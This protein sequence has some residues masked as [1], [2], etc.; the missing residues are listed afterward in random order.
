MASI[1]KKEPIFYLERTWNNKMK[2]PEKQKFSGEA[3]K[4]AEVHV[5]S[6]SLGMEF[7]YEKTLP[8]FCQVGDELSWS[9]T[10]T[11]SKFENVLAG[12]YKTAWR[13]VVKDHFT[14]LPAEASKD[15]LK[16]SFFE[17]IT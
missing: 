9:W 1:Y 12:S 5:N 15:E 16:K 7:F 17:A 8:D 4:K 10:E 14:P 11:F 13:E 6:G 2:L 3:G